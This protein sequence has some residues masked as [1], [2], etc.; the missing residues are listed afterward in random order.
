MTETNSFFTDAELLNV[1][2]NVL[3]GGFDTTIAGLLFSIVCIASYPEV[4]EKI[5]EE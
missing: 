2:D 5:Y 3:V 1:V 4:Q